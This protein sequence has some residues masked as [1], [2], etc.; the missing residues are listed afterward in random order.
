[1]TLCSIPAF[2]VVNKSRN[3]TTCNDGVSR[4]VFREQYKIKRLVYNLN[5]IWHS[6][7]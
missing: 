5:E 2:V 3:E 1:M 7:N 4:T 6:E